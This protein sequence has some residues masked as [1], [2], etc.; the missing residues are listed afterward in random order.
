MKTLA[1]FKYARRGVGFCSEAPAAPD[2]CTLSLR[3]ALPILCGR[4]VATRTD[5]LDRVAGTLGD[6]HAGTFD[7]VGAESPLPAVE[8]GVA[9]ARAAVADAIVAAG[10]GD[11]LLRRWQRRSEEHTSELQSRGH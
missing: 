10:G 2:F 4:S 11:T 9:A 7:R 8:E 1:V 6:A 5:L 3:D